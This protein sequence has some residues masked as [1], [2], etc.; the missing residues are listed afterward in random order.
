MGL[1]AG[2]STTITS[3]V[4]EAIGR[5]FISIGINWVFAPTLDLLNDICEPLN[6][7][8]TYG[9]RGETVSDHALAF[10]Q[11]LKAGGVSPC[12]NAR[13]SGA[14]LEIFRSEGSENLAGIAHG[15]LQISQLEEYIPLARMTA[16]NPSDS[17]QQAGAFHEF[18]EPLRAV[19]AIRTACDMVLRTTSGF[20][21]PTVASFEAVPDEDSSVC[22]EHAPLLSYMSGFDMVK[23]PKDSASIQAS[24]SALQAVMGSVNLP[25][26]LLAEA[27]ARISTL[28]SQHLTWEKVL[29]LP[30]TTATADLAESSLAHL[31]YRNSTT[32]LSQSPSPLLSIPPT[33]IVLLLTPTVPRT[34][35]DSPSDPFEPLGRALSRSIQRLRH[36]PYTLSAGLTSTHLAFLERATAVVLVLCNTSSALTESQD[37]VIKAVQSTLH[38]R[39]SRPG[40][41]TTRKLVV[42]AGDP[43]DLRQ[44]WT[45][46][47][48]ACCY[49]YTR[50]ALET[51][52]EVILGERTG[53]GTLPLQDG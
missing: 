25:I 5:E 8:Q 28:K 40:Q 41:E 22:I 18:P 3:R 43:R 10:V 53:P 48:G 16:R 6:A 36:V 35:P 32:V 23:L 29:N 7:S 38:Q 50:G 2:N 42:G 11:G 47:W 33:S 4:G 13:P 45:G 1:A 20:R 37:E 27:A 21:G 46:W 34:N 39:D 51:V 17:L 15:L 24:I 9:N 14:V 30:S 12:P 19:K 44:P 26:T 49:E 52:A 31:A